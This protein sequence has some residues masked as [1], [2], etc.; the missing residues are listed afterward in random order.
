M[1]VWNT[2]KKWKALLFEMTMACAPSVQKADVL[3]PAF[4]QFD[5]TTPGMQAI[6][7]I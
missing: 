2:L 5:N 7:D 6:G 3:G 1:E 4:L